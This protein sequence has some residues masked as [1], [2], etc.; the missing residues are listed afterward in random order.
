MADAKVEV[1]LPAVNCVFQLIQSNL[2]WIRQFHESG[3]VS[4]LRHISERIGAVSLSPGGVGR[5]LHGHYHHGADDDK[6]ISE[7]ARL[8]VDWLEHVSWD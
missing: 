6:E 4:T 5:V 7:R 3:I 8:A 2:K 1:R